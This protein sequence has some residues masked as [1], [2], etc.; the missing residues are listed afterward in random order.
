MFAYAIRDSRIRSMLLVRDRLA[1]SHFIFAL[2]RK[3]FVFG[4]EL[5]GPRLPE[6]PFEIDLT[7]PQLYFAVN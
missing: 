2:Y 1:R 4:S 7:V 3:A 6:L 5:M